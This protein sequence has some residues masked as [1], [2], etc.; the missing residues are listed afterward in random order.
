MVEQK[1]GPS[2]RRRSGVLVAALLPLVAGLFA[3]PAAKAATSPQ[4]PVLGT[5]TLTADRE[6]D[7]VRATVLVHGVRRIPGASVVYFSGGIPSGETSASWGYFNRIAVDRLV[8]PYTTVG[9]VR[10][11]DFA[12]RRV[13]LPLHGQ[14]ANGTEQMLVSPEAAWPSG[15]PGGT[16]YT[17][18]AVMPELPDDLEQVD[19]LFGNADVVHDVPVED[20]V[21]E[22]AVAQEGPIRTGEGWPQIDQA[23]AAASLEPEKSVVPMTVETSDLEETVTERSEADTTSVDLAADV[24]FAVDSAELGPDAGQALQKAADEVNA[25]AKGG[26]VRVVGHTDSTGSDPHNLDLSQRRAQAVAEA[27]K[28]LITISGVTYDVSGVGEADPVDSNATDEGRRRNRRVSV[29]IGSG[30]GK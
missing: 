13:Y 11:A 21:L 14:D 18:Y 30:E 22:P 10:L 3:A 6:A 7:G 8:S 5:T 9:K 24:L 19:I 1:P 4:V 25:S 23:A 17:F 26:Q 16:F 2:G 15:Q 28:P 27:L 20:G 29:V 12:N